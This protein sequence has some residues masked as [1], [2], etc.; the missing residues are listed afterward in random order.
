MNFSGLVEGEEVAVPCRH[1]SSV[2]IKIRICAGAPV[3]QCPKCKGTCRVEVR[4]G[5]DGWEIKTEPIQSAPSRR[6]D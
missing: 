5:A 4:Q 6:P 3:V 2:S 1:C